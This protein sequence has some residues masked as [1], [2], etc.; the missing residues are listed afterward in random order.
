VTAY[1]KATVDGDGLLC[2]KCGSKYAKQEKAAARKRTTTK[3]AKR[4]DM[5]AALDNQGT[6][7]KSLREYTTRVIA[8]NIDR[9]D[10]FGDMQRVDMDA[11]CQI[12]CR[13]RSLD[14][15]TLKLF[16]EPQ[17]E[18]LTLYDCARIDAEQ[19]GSI[20]TEVPTL[21]HLD[22]HHAGNMT[23]SVLKHYSETL[24][25]LNSF[26]IRGA[27]LVSRK[28]YI[29]FFT[30]VGK[31]LKHLTLSAT[32]LTSPAVIE[33][34][35]THCHNLETLELSTLPRFDD[36]SLALLAKLTNLTSLNISSAGGPISDATLI[37]V[38]DAIGAGLTEVNIAGNPGLTGK[39][40]DAIHACCASLQILNLDSCEE[41]TDQDIFNLFTNWGKNRGLR[42]LHLSRVTALKNAGLLAAIKHSGEM[43]EVLDINSCNG[44]TKHGVMKALEGCGKKLRRFDVAFVREVDDEVVE[45]VWEKGVTGLAVWGCTKVSQGV[46][47]EVGSVLVGREAD[48]VGA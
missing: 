1:S 18:R 34:I 47:V 31:R 38:L 46:K 24:T 22:L 16:F 36:T 41:I 29:D 9:V 25:A 4:E 7:C 20:A 2:S 30:T 12:V 11:I 8:A 19:L 39:T 44:V 27:F 40:L 43:L 23:D 3:R 14:N 28:A 42:E 17:G 10:G 37:S 5:R 26:H 35:V 45:K 15:N 13:N 32:A 21:K 6:G 48:I 33:A